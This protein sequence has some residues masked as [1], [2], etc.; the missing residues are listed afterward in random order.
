[1]SSKKSDKK[2]SKY[3]DALEEN[4]KARYGTT[5]EELQE[6]IGVLEDEIKTVREA[7]TLMEDHINKFA[8]RLKN[9]EFW[10]K[11]VSLALHDP[12]TL[13]KIPLDRYGYAAVKQCQQDGSMPSED[14]VRLKPIPRIPKL[15]VFNKATPQEYEQAPMED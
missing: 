12:H 11:H 7:I 3:Q 15:D 1:M 2:S 6:K 5:R 8:P 13:L 4:T 14:K 10:G 9:I